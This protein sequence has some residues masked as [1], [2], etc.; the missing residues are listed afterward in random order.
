MKETTIKIMTWGADRKI[1]TNG[2]YETQWLKLVSE[3]G[4]LCDN[5]AK[6]KDIRDDIGDMYVVV[7]MMGRIAGLTIED[8]SRAIDASSM[9]TYSINAK[10]L[11]GVL[12]NE[13]GGLRFKGRMSVSS[14]SDIMVVLRE[15]AFGAGSTLDECVDIAYNDIK[16]RKGHLNEHG[17]FIK[18]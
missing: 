13:I 18:E 5:I 17:V 2:K 6:S 15:I 3:Y 8:F 1:T 14:V 4:E 7:V 10:A 11:I 16:D 12:H 9:P